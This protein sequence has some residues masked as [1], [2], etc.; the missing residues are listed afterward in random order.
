VFERFT[1]QARSV[2]VSAQDEARLLNHS[3]IGT[4]HILL[5]LL[6]AGEGIGAQALRSLGISLEAVRKEVEET[7]GRGSTRPDGDPPFTPRA[8]KVLELSFREAMAMNHSDIGTEHLLLGLLRD[9]GGVGAQ[10]LIRLG[11]DLRHVRQEVTRLL[12]AR[13]YGG[14]WPALRKRPAG[15]PAPEGPSCP[16]CRAALGAMAR[17]RTIAVQADSGETGMLSIDV[18]YCQACGT[19]L[20]MF[21]SEKR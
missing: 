11:A 14:E 5:G 1:D 9:G 3:F 15:E 21:R 18:V 20:H 4:E 10:V 8:K 12:S 2:L 19:T 7:I 16:Q 6:A 13:W 17:F